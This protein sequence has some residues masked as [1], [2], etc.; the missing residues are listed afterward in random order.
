MWPFTRSSPEPEPD[1]DVLARLDA[2][3]KRI[4][5]IDVEWSEWFDKFRRLYARL[6][7][8]VHDDEKR[9]EAPENPSNG[10]S[11]AAPMNPLA[12]AL[13]RRPGASGGL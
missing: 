6:A 8:R 9:P 12:A 2:L 10:R 13:L 11:G 7:K 1:L 4:E 5:T 3:E